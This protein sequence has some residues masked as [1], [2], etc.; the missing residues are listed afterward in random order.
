MNCFVVKTRNL[1]FIRIEILSS[2]S[3]ST[4]QITVHYRG[5]VGHRNTKQYCKTTTV[6]VYYTDMIKH[7]FSY[8]NRNGTDLSCSHALS[9]MHLFFSLKV[10][11][12]RGTV[13]R[14]SLTR[15]NCAVSLYRLMACVR[16]T[17]F[18]ENFKSLPGEEFLH[19]FL[20]P[21]FFLRIFL[22]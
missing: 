5:V 1:V 12:G 20:E 3:F 18:F 9:I 10:V 17:F 11:T 7:D 6:L 21:H 14:D 2:V 4:T 19:F 13:F 8:S 15:G 16:D 22:S